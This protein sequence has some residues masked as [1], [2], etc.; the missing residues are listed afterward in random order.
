MVWMGTKAVP[1]AAQRLRG[2][3]TRAEEDPVH[4]KAAEQMLATL[5][6]MKG[7]ALKMGQM[8]SYM[9]GALPAEAEPAFRRVLAKLQRDAPTL[10]WE[11]ARRVLEEDLGNVQDHFASIE[12][13]PFA[14][15][16]IGQVHRAVLHDGTEVAVKIQYPNIR[17]AIEADMDNL[18]LF[19]GMARPF[20]GV[21]GAGSS[22][23]FV[24]ET[25]DEI[26]ARTLEELDYR[27]EARM[28]TELRRLLAGVEGLVIPQVYHQHSGDRV[29][30]SRFEPGEGLDDVADAPQEL[31]DTWARILTKAVVDQLYVH[32]L[33]NGDPHPGNYLFRRDGTVV[34]LDFGCVKEI[35]PAMN[36][37]MKRYGKA[38]IKARDTDTVEDWAAFDRAFKDAQNLWD[39]SPEMYE[40][41]KDMLVYV[42]TP[43][44][45]DEPFDFTVEFTA[46]VNDLMIEKKMEM[47]YPDGRR[48]PKMPKI[49]S[50]PADYTFIHRLQWGFFSVLTRLGA[51]VNWYALLP[52]DMQVR[53][54]G[55]KAPP[56]APVA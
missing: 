52:P 56:V 47:L 35:S 37:D 43:L 12:E 44:T 11:A 5:G 48:I 55:S 21:M 3:D 38:L 54:G 49:P 26:R 32:R 50:M 22:L 46:G 15:A 28:Q 53:R 7:L 2:R 51:K 39:A 33:F 27:R 1:L 36:A 8:M 42:A 23:E 13:V 18:E 14:A 31:R 4:V 29:M 25:M 10:P 41:A 24:K 40:M 9:D 17:A 6:E 34:L 16:S 30:T 19:K 45:V 20:L